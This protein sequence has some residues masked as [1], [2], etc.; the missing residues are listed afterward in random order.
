MA[1]KFLSIYGFTEFPIFRPA[2]SQQKQKHILSFIYVIL[3]FLN[4]NS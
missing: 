1:K 3:D 2:P 4:R